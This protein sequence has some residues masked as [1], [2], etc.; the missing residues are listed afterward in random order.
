M[1]QV[2]LVLASL[3]GAAAIPQG[4]MAQQRGSADG[5]E[6]SAGAGVVSCPYSLG[7]K[8]QHTIAVPRLDVRYKDWFYANPIDGV[9]VQTNVRDGQY[10]RHSAP[11]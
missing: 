8:K 1:K 10:R 2:L 4:A 11:T 5:W 6:V 9:G 3:A 7:S